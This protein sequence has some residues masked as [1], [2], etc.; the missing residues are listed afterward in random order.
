M[1]GR[2]GGAYRHSMTDITMIRE[3]ISAG[4]NRAPEQLLPVVTSENFPLC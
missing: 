2:H 3:A 4:D 1:A